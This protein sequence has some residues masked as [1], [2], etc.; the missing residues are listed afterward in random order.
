ME[1][2]S[3]VKIMILPF[4]S[5]IEIFFREEHNKK[6]EESVYS[7]SN[8][9]QDGLRGQENCLRHRNLRIILGTSFTAIVKQVQCHLNNIKNI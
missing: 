2:I 9:R 5:Y 6:K 7:L 8:R 4:D 3:N 1:N